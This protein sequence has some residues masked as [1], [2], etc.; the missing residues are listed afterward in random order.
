MSGAEPWINNWPK[1]K[2]IKAKLKETRDCT[3][4]SFSEVWNAPYEAAHNHMKRQFGRKNRSGPAW[5]NCED[6]IKRCPKTKMD[7]LWGYKEEDKIITLGQF[8]KQYPTG[9]YWVF[10]RGH[11]L[12]VIDGIV[13]DHSYKPRRKVKLAYRVHV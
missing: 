12:A 13:Y 2:E 6:A 3:V 8:L 7:K 5:V 10:V 1:H 11:A 4:I 9:R